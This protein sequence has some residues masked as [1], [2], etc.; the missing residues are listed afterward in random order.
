MLKNAS[1][2]VSLSVPVLVTFSI[3]AHAGIATGLPCG[4]QIT[5]TTKLTADIG[6]CS[7]TALFIGGAANQQSDITLDLNGH[8]I[9]GG[10]ILLHGGAAG[11]TTIKGPGNVVNAD[12]AI[13]MLFFGGKLLIYDITFTNN[14]IA[15]AATSTGFGHVRFLNNVVLGGRAGSIGVRIAQSAADV[16]GNVITGNSTAG[17]YVDNSAANIFQ[18]VITNNGDGFQI[19]NTPGANISGNQ[20]LGNRGNGISLL[21]GGDA[22]TIQGNVIGGNGGSGVTGAVAHGMLIQDNFVN[23]NRANGIDLNFDGQVIGNRL[24]GNGTDLHFGGQGTTCFAQNIF[25]SSVPAVLP[26]CP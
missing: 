14:D 10:G 2:R 26:A 5:Q 8:T 3:A 15:F 16:Y 22:G 11:V 9:N 17:V 21:G 7:G 1:R 12:T 25:Q 4:T 19:Q 18:N 23:A 13:A 20:I 24:A 6:P